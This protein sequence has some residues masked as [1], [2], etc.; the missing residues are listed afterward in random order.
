MLNMRCSCY[1]YQFWHEILCHLICSW[2]YGVATVS[3]LLEIIVL[4]CKRALIKRWYSAKETYNFKEPT[5]RSHPIPGIVS[6]I[7]KG[8]VEIFWLCW[9]SES[10]NLRGTNDHTLIIQ[11]W[12]PEKIL[13]VQMGFNLMFEF[14]PSDLSPWKI[15]WYKF[16]VCC[17]P[18]Y[19]ILNWVF[20]ALT[21]HYSIWSS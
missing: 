15:W 20:I 6:G 16:I 11:D 4:F 18:R 14:V 13:V 2:L 7:R 5:N 19:W 12:P 1:T 10:K 8:A 9:Y 3:R 17:I 21:I